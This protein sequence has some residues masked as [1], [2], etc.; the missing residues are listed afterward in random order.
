M[1]SF[2]TSKYFDLHTHRIKG[3][4]NVQILNIF[5]QDMP[6]Y[7]AENLFSTGIHPWHIEKVNQEFSFQ[8]IEKACELKNMLAIGECGLDRSIATNFALQEKYF[9]DHIRVADKFSK[10]LI[11]HGV[12]AYSDL[13][14]LKK[15]TKSGVPWILHGYQGNHQ[16]TQDLIAH[17]FYF[18]VGEL[19]LKTISKHEV[20]KVIPLNH[21]FLETDD[22]QISI[23]NIYS[24]AANALEIDKEE[25]I[26]AIRDNFTRLFGANKET[27]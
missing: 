23:E 3:N 7:T 21:L 14:K 2:T 26:A 17:G 10:P 20:L 24:V 25:L 18:S 19:F 16:T 1:T 27:S 6:D 5:A 9:K 12:R 13:L 11:I 15:E 22:R 4:D 8:A